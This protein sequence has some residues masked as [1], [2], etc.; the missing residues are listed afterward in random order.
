MS[1]EQNIDDIL[2][3]LRDSYSNSSSEESIENIEGSDQN[4][5]N[6][7]LQERLKNQYISTSSS[8]EAEKSDN[9]DGYFID[10]DFLTEAALAEE[11]EITEAVEADEVFEVVD[12]YDNASVILEDIEGQPINEFEYLQR[13][14]SEASEDEEEFEEFEKYEEDDLPEDNV[15]ELIAA[16]SPIPEEELN[17]RELLD[18][19]NA[20]IEIDALFDEILVDDSEEQ[21]EE[22]FDDSFEELNLEAESLIEE[23]T[24][25]LDTPEFNEQEQIY[26]DKSLDDEEY[27]GFVN[28]DEIDQISSDDIAVSEPENVENIP[29]TEEKQEPREKPKKHET[30][31]ASMRKTGI[32]FTTDEIYNSTAK[33]AHTEEDAAVE[34]AEILNTLGEQDKFEEAPITDDA[35]LDLS[36]INIMMQFC[37]KQEL[38]KTIGDEKVDG[39]LKAEDL[40]VNETE[41]FSEFDD[42]EYADASQNEE[43]SSKYKK[44]HISALFSMLGCIAIAVFALIYE[45]LPVFDVELS[46]ILSYVEY[47]AVYALLGL[48]FVAFAAAICYKKLWNGMKRAF[49]LTPN[50]Y[51]IIAIILGLTAIYD[52]VVV[53]ILSITGDALPSMYNAMAVIITAL[54]ASADY[55]TVVL[56]MKAFEVYSSDSKKY[57]AIKE[58]RHGGIAAK[59]YDGG[60]EE[61]KAVYS[62]KSIDFPN[63]FF[64]SVKAKHSKN[65]LLTVLIIPVLVIGIIASVVAAILGASAYASSAAFLVCV[66]AILPVVLIFTEILPYTV[67]ISKLSK[68]GSAFAGIEAVKKYEDC[69]VFVFNDLHM[70]K[71]CKTE[72]V[73][74]AIYDTSVGYLVLGCIDALY[75]KIGGPLSGMKMNLPDVFKFQNVSIKRITKNGIEAIIDKKHSLVVGEAAFLQRYGLNFPPNEKENGRSTLCVSLN[76]KISAKLSVR[77]E[78]EPLFEMLVERLNA[79]GI[80]TA[81]ETY[82][83]LINSAT[84]ASARTLGESPISVVHKNSDDFTAEKSNRYRSEA[85]GV[86]S[87]GSRLKLA[88]LIVW[89]KKLSKL[90]GITQKIAIAFSA[91]GA[92][93]ATLLL[94]FGVMEYANQLYILLYLL[95]EAIT[96]LILTFT[97]LPSSKYFTVDALYTE[98]ERN[99]ARLLEKQQKY[100]QRQ[101][102]KQKTQN[103]NRVK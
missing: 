97:L 74:I 82:D 87:C 54:L 40:N 26:A 88:E 11:L 89:I 38:E 66:Y 73:G 9:S 81:V 42:K 63:G 3:L 101:I 93:V 10:T 60:L 80:S 68:R 8:Y 20:D 69:N 90:N 102:K 22:S 18:E 39:F 56:E 72:D 51:S 59:M 48:Q 37:E 17:T 98:L 70:F 100:E 45:L 1:R 92:V 7:A 32:D 67:A 33:K 71:K 91:T 94:V 6:E 4:I 50:T 21:T 44:S 34:Q 57:T 53:I 30:F 86:I 36:T 64:R 52:M 19:D 76:G 27:D 77:Y 49:S 28:I 15:D 75:S 84:V 5:S 61:D 83:P 58:A 96:M 78:T 41:V 43:I 47:P 103:R 12:S 23:I 13:T 55:L 95:A 65:K 29:A 25:D 35:E 85:D 46:G 2:Q 16:M 99:N 14:L 24:L 79:E 31:L 62:I